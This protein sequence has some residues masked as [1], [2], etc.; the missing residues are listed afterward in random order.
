MKLFVQAFFP[1]QFLLTMYV[2]IYSFKKTLTGGTSKTALPPRFSVETTAAIESGVLAP[3]HHEIVNSISHTMVGY[4]MNPSRN[5]YNTICRR[6]IHQYPTL[7]D[8][9]GQ[10]YVS[11]FKILIILEREYCIRQIIPGGKL[12]RF[13]G[14]F[15]TANVLLLKIF[16]QISVS[17]LTTQSMVP[18]GLKF[19]TVKVFPTY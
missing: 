13:F 17:P 1:Q 12:L 7:K 10:G 19:S 5:D 9:K 8:H 3:K 6:L 15:L 11:A 2:K 14:I 4:T 16:L 18:S